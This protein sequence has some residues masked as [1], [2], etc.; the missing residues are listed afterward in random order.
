MVKIPTKK[1]L[2][3][4]NSSNHQGPAT[5]ASAA[6]SKT[7]RGVAGVVGRDRGT[8]GNRP[9]SS[10][11]KWN[12]LGIC[13]HICIYIFILYIYFLFMVRLTCSYHS[14]CLRIY[15]N[16]SISCYDDCQA[17]L[18]S[19]DASTF[20]PYWWDNPK[21]HM[22]EWLENLPHVANKNTVGNS[23]FAFI[24]HQVTW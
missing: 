3:L 17:A 6:I 8:G 11:R 15:I 16:L 7:S 18:V 1:T 5:K 23:W 2:A 14:I 19:F 13:W 9:V 12:L 4:S 22:P 24:S 10:G 21:S 20:W